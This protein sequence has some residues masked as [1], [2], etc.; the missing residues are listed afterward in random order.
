M[1]YCP[2]RK[3]Y[4]SPK[5]VEAWGCDEY[6]DEQLTLFNEERRTKK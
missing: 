6:K 2:I 1:I 5:F 3:Y 4:P